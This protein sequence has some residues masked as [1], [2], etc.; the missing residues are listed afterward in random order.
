MPD[1]DFKNLSPFEFE[2]LTRD[3]LQKH[4]NVTYESFSNNS[5]DGGVDFRYSINKLSNVILQCKKYKDVKTLIPVLK[6]EA[7]KVKK[8]KPKR[9]ILITSLSL[10]PSQKKAIF[11]IFAPFIEK[12][13]EIFSGD[14]LNNLLG[15]YPTI[16]KQHFKLWLSS[17][18]ILSR[19]LHSK[20][21]N[22]SSFEEEEIKETTRLYVKNE[23]YDKA[24]EIIKSKKYVI[25]SGIPGIGKT[26]LARILVYHFLSN[27]FTDFV[28][29]SESID[30]GYKVYQ[31][32]VKQVFLFDDFLG[33]NFL[34][35]KLRNNEEQRIVKFI[36]KVSESSDKVLIFTTREYILEQAK[37]QYDI[38]NAPS[39]DVAKCVIDLSHYTKLVR[40]KILYNHLYFSGIGQDYISNLL[41][42]GNYRY[43]ISHR[44]YNPRIIQTFINPEVS[45]S[46]KPEEFMAK[47]S[48][49]LNYPDSVW[50]HVFE[51]QISKLSQFTL[52]NIMIAGTPILIPDLKKITQAFAKEFSSKYSISYSELDF[53]KCIR[54][55]ENTFIITNIDKEGVVAVSF[56]NPSVQDFLVRYFK[57]YQDTIADIISSAIYFNQLFNVITIKQKEISS[58]NKIFIQKNIKAIW[59]NKLTK[60]FQRLGSSRI[61]QAFYKERSNFTW[62]RYNYTD[63]SKLAEINNMFS[64][65]KNA[66]IK[67]FARNI[68]ADIL[69]PTKL[70]SIDF[71]EYILLVRLYRDQFDFDANRLIRDVFSNI[72]YLGQMVTFES[73]ETVFPEEF[74]SFASESFFSVR[75]EELIQEEMENLDEERLSSTLENIETLNNK[76]N[77]SVEEQTELLQQKIDEKKGKEES[78]DWDSENVDF[79]EPNMEND[80]TIIRNMFDSLVKEI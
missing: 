80:E 68:F 63:Y 79:T 65:E 52:A 77:L 42:D 1:Y 22:L 41:K 44:N 8:L 5:K 30:D 60:D 64:E 12:E 37:L 39:L 17:A 29:L 38:F 26:T 33:R 48:Q 19:I 36:K 69:L 58:N 78:Y 54:E 70:D 35:Q 49:F 10:N 7:L 66:E 53:Q 51:N 72:T 71:K 11:D 15:R 13:N 28:F 34:G 21:H 74:E 50:K 6:R 62:F 57:D 27:G 20:T 73:L 31:E 76:Y 55:L 61:I 32:G 24:L 25:I 16:E 3:L 67:E 43:I 18:N 14:D 40:A 9:Y 75:L 47:I 45:S 56:K 2:D 59:T 23:S 4:Y 46:I